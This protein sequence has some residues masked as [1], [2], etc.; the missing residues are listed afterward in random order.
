MNGT[1]SMCGRCG[2]VKDWNA[3]G[4]DPMGGSVEPPKV[5]RTQTF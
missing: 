1:V 5:K 2:C 3:A 4:A